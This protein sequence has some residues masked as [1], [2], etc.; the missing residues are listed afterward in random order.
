L[1]GVT[2]A[3][4]NGTQFEN[5]NDAPLTAGQFF[6]QALGRLVDAKG[7]L[8]GGLIQAEEVSLED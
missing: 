7:T 1:F 8:N 5:L 4:N 3:T 2:V 6:D